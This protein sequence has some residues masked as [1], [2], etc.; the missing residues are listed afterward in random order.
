MA[1][2][3]LKNGNEDSGRKHI[4]NIGGLLPSLD[5]TQINENWFVTSSIKLVQLS[6]S[7]A[8]VFP[9]IFHLLERTIRLSEK[10]GDERSWTMAHLL[11]GRA[12]WSSDRLQDAVNYLGKGKDKAEELGDSDILAQSASFIGIF[13]FIKG[14]QKKA[15]PYL[16]L[17]VDL[18]ENTEKY[19]MTFEAPILLAYCD[20]DRGNFSSGH[21]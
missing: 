4:E 18:A 17:A 19:P 9:L 1:I 15:I 10:I 2:E 13:Y 16:E 8:L 21:W 20:V 7:R 3:A 14:L 11:M 12:Y 5:D 6:Q